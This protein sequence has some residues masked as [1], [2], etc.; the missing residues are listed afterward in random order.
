VDTSG[1]FFPW[2]AILERARTERLDRLMSLALASSYLD[3]GMD[4]ELL[5]EAFDLA[6]EQRDQ[7]VC[8]ILFAGKPP[9]LP[10]SEWRRMREIMGVTQ[11]QAQQE[12]N[13]PPAS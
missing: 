5:V 6:I 11:F 12:K 1:L 3:P 7:D 13:A 2:E 8:G 9:L 4:A 10:E